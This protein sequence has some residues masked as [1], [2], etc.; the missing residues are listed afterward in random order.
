MNSWLTATI[1]AANKQVRVVFLEVSVANIAAR[2]L[3]TRAGF[4]QA[5]LRPHYYS[6]NSDALVLQLELDQRV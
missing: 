6:D 2:H 4:L 5:G 1:L 3:Y